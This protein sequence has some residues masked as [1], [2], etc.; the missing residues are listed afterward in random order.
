MNKQHVCDK[1]TFFFAISKLDLFTISLQFFPVGAQW[2]LLYFSVLGELKL[3]REFLFFHR[4][5]N[6]DMDMFA[7]PVCAMSFQTHCRQKCKQVSIVI[8][9]CQMT[10]FQAMLQTKCQQHWWNNHFMHSL[11]KNWWRT[12][13]KIEPRKLVCDKTKPN[14]EQN[15]NLDHWKRKRWFDNAMR[16][17]NGNAELRT[18]PKHEQW[19]L[20]GQNMSQCFLNCIS[21]S[22]TV[23]LS[24][25]HIAGV[26]SS[27]FRTVAWP[28]FSCDCNAQVSN[29]FD[30]L[31]LLLMKFVWLRDVSNFLPFPSF[32]QTFVCCFLKAGSE[33]HLLFPKRLLWD[34]HDPCM[35]SS[36]R[37]NNIVV[38]WVKTVALTVKK[39]D[40]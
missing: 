1:M 22:D 10:S 13:L 25:T 2:H 18:E 19:Q 15:E 27:V 33:I 31:L 30:K 32:H 12:V 40:S 5:P 35:L 9:W 8:N 6:I 14:R 3:L 21:A 37:R 39:K 17:N 29:F 26:S 24:M 20:N 38:C 28:Q 4:F 7:S 11:A 34:P 16:K 23:M 36:Q